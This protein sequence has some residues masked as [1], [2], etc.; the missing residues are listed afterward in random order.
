VCSVDVHSVVFY[1]DMIKVLTEV[2]SMLEMPSA[3][4][5]HSRIFLI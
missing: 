4:N 3:Q 2:Y 1:F 5:V